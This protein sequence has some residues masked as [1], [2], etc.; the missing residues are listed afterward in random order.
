MSRCLQDRQPHAARAIE[1][2]E[3]CEGEK[4]NEKVSEEATRRV[5][6]DVWVGPASGAPAITCGQIK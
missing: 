2:W 1:A 5:A 3:V 4:E 6:W